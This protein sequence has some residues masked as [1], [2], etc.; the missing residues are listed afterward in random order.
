MQRVFGDS[1]NVRLEKSEIKKREK[2]VNPC[3]I[4][5]VARVAGKKKGQPRTVDLLKLV[6]MAGFEPFKS[7]ALYGSV[8][9][10]TLKIN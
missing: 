5:S 10:F 8:L 2:S 7:V 4:R 3:H 6:E 1:E 9:V